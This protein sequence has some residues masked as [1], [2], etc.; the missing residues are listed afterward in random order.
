MRILASWYTTMPTWNGLSIVT[1]S[2]GNSISNISPISSCNRDGYH[3]SITRFALSTTCWSLVYIILACLSFASSSFHVLRNRLG[4][5]TAVVKQRWEFFEF[6]PQLLWDSNI[7]LRKPKLL[8]RSQPGFKPTNLF[9]RVL[10]M[11]HLSGSARHFLQQGAWVHCVG[12][13]PGHPAR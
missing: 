6:F 3:E 7:H 11:Y 2:F 10:V 1:F 9:G 13:K 12:I 8:F 4:R 5:N